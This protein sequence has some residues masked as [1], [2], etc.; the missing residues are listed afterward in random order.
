MANVLHRTTKQYL[1]SVNTPDYPVADWIVNPDLSAVTGFDSKYWLISGDNVTLMDQSARDAVD[2]AEAQAAID[3]ER[4][5][6]KNRIDNEKVLTAIAKVMMD[7]INILRAEH[8]LTARTL[9]QVKTAIKSEVDN[10]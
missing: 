6:Q 8:S 2:V 10:I 7:E 3:N 1:K 5:T 9:A 4:A